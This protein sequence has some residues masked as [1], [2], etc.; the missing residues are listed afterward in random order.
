MHPSLKLWR[1]TWQLGLDA[2][3]VVALRLAKLSM[4]GSGADAE[5]R[6]MVSEKIAAISAAQ[7]AAAWAF[8]R[9]KGIEAAATAAMVPVKRAVEANHRRLSRA[10]KVNGLLATLRRL[11]QR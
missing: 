5:C 9:G 11:A 7:A 4:G 8:A 3:R 10:R 1:D 6:R 2:Q